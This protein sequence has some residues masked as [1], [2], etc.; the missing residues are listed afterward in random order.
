MNLRVVVVTYNSAAVIERCLRSCAGWPVT[1]VDNGSTDGTSALVKNLALPHVALIENTANRGFAGGVNQAAAL[2]QEEF[3]LSLNPD[4]ELVSGLPP[5]CDALKTAGCGIATG[6]LLGE[7]GRDQAGFAIRRF[8]TP[9]SLAFEAL[10]WNRIFPGNPVN[11]RYRYAGKDWDRPGEV[12][13][14]AGAFLAFRRAL[15]AGLGGFDERFHPVWFEDVDFCKRASESGARIY[16]L[17]MVTARHTGGHSVR[18]M[19]WECREVAWYV[20]LLKYASKHFR[21]RGRRAVGAAVAVGSVFRALF[22][23]ARRRSVRPVAVYAEVFRLGVRC[24]FSDVV[25]GGLGSRESLQNNG[26]VE[27]EQIEHQRIGNRSHLHVL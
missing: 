25:K 5:I 14:P 23:T 24:V 18:R 19:A 12:E 8:P 4:V 13:Q 6:R 21:P 10:G 16:Y 1:V 26:A 2:A 27:L 20:S 15:W 3:L 17:P 11:R 22:F 9:A 7:D